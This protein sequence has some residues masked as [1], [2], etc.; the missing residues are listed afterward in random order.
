ME[1][2]KEILEPSGLDRRPGLPQPSATEPAEANSD[3]R[4]CEAIGP[5]E[6]SEA[7]LR[8]SHPRDT[9]IDCHSELWVSAIPPLP[10]VPVAADARR[11]SLLRLRSRSYDES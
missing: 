1:R 5:G 8:A 9:C 6:K 3:E 7:V 11:Q 10:R 2:A 4:D